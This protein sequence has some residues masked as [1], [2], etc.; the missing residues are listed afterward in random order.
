MVDSDSIGSV[1]MLDPNGVTNAWQK[2]FKAAE[3]ARKCSLWMWKVL[4]TFP[5]VVPKI[6][7]GKTLIFPFMR[8]LRSLEKCYLNFELSVRHCYLHIHWVRYS[9]STSSQ[10]CPLGCWS[11]HFFGKI[12]RKCFDLHNSALHNYLQLI[13]TDLRQILRKRFD[14]HNSAR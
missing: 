12:L 6:V 10:F 7:G 13:S 11:P 5:N 9:E 1:V 8:N 14:L 2:N 4:P 3:T